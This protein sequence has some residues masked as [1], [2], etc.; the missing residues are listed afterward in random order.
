LP[1]PDCGGRATNGAE[2][3]IPFE[4]PRAQ[5]ENT[6][7]RAYHTP[8]H[9]LTNDPELQA[10][11]EQAVIRARV[12]VPVRVATP[13]GVGPVTRLG[14]SH[15]NPYLCSL[16][17]RFGDWS[18]DDLRD[19][20]ERRLGRSIGTVYVGDLLAICAVLEDT[21]QVDRS[22]LPQQMRITR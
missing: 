8:V 2:W 17:E 16:V 21:S 14:R 12:R 13:E 1:Q 3:P 18:V 15:M 9:Y 7:K 20:V 19:M 4:R 11:M 22:A 6:A 5:F 10:A